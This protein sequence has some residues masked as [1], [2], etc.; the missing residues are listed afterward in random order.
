MAA[1]NRK[2]LIIGLN[3]EGFRRRNIQGVAN[4]LFPILQ[5]ISENSRGG[6]AIRIDIFT[7]TFLKRKYSSSPPCQEK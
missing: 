2:E 4:A 7:V 6:D 1:I 3:D 5:N